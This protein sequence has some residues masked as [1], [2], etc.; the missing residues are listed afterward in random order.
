VAKGQHL[1]R[2][3]QGI[4]KRYYEHRDTLM[5]Q[6]L[7]EMVSELYLSDGKKAEKLWVSAAAAMEKSGADRARVKQIVEAR[8]VAGLAALVN[9]L[10]GGAPKPVP[11]KAT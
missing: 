6:R 2:H 11:R 3:Q 4:V 8:N 7:G 1:S 9:E 10:A 5:I